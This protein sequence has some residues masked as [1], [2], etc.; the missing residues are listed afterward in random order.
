MSGSSIALD[1]NF[2]LYLL[3]GDKTLAEFLHDKK[4]Y[5]SVITELELLGY[6][7]ITAKEQLQIKNF[8]ENCIVVNINEEVKS[9]YTQ[10][11]KKYRLKLGDAVTASTAIYLDLPLI[12]TDIDFSK[13]QELQ[14]TQYNPK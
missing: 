11:R 1:T 7:G 8:L 13:I 14:L 3:G 4:G 5:I 9:I 2:I 6:Q 12:T 10:L